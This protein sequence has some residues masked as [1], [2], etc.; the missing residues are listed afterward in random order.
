MGS[1]SVLLGGVVAVF[2]SWTRAGGPR[3]AHALPS[4]LI[5]THL[6]LATGTLLI[7]PATL[8]LGAWALAYRLGRARNPRSARF[9]RRLGIITAFLLGMTALT[10]LLVYAWKYARPFVTHQA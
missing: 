4:G 6:S 2:T 3:G 8:A 10:G 1:A 5:S 9:H 7:L